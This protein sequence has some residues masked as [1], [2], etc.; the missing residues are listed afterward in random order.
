[1]PGAHG[2][3]PSGAG[4]SVRPPLSWPQKA[5]WSCAPSCTVAAGHTVASGSKGQ[6]CAR[7]RTPLG[8]CRLSLKPPSTPGCYS[9]LR[10]WAGVLQR[11]CL[12]PFS[13]K[14]SLGFSVP[15]T[16]VLH[17]HG[18]PH[19]VG[20]DLR[21]PLPGKMAGACWPLPLPDTWNRLGRGERGQARPE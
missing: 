1:M 14:G 7:G 13:T 6:P 4:P 12:D 20:K 2:R 5:L 18:S 8:P 15:R 19:N 9:A 11:A 17:P 3:G 21:E 10:W 16:G